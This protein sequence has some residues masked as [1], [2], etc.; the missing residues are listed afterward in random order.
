MPTLV[1]MLKALIALPSI[2]SA[3][4]S[5]DTSNLPVINLLAGWLEELGFSIDIQPLADQPGKANMVATLGS[6][7]GGLVLAGH[8][9]TVPFDDGAW[10]SDPFKLTEANQNFYGL[11]TTDMKGFFPVAIEAA[12]AFSDENLQQPLI[13]L[14]TADEETSMSGARALA[15]SG[16]PKARYAVIG[17]P[18]DLK[19]VRMHKGVMMESII[20]EGRSGHSSNPALGRSAVDA[21]YQVLGALMDLRNNW[22]EQ[23]RNPGFDIDVPTMNLASIHGGDAP[24]RICSHCELRFDVRLLPGMQNEEVRHQIHQTVT[25]ALEGSGV[26]AVM[27]SLLEG[28]EAFM[29]ASDSPLVQQAEKLTGHQAISANFAT[30]AAFMQALGM[31]TVVMGPGSIDCAHRPNEYLPQNQIDPAVKL[32]KNLISEYC[33]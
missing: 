28:V 22:G 7:P 10:N 32:L 21:M 13:I 19:P 1:D 24:N 18:T 17:E 31:Q 15:A 2:S 29:E 20:L 27:K 5:L 6:G 8:T 30:E 14:A 12:R 3:D 23:Y 33:L 9:D 26:Q 25:A 4:S 11:G 16:Q